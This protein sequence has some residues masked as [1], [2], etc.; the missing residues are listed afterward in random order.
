MTS[1][2]DVPQTHWFAHAS[3]TMEVSEKKLMENFNIKLKG[4]NFDLILTILLGPRVT[5]MN[6]FMIGALPRVHTFF[7]NERK[8]VPH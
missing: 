2:Y 7:L 3:E 8:K 5:L 4:M 1:N 6:G